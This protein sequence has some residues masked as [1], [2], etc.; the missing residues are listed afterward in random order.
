MYLIELLTPLDQF[1]LQTYS[2]KKIYTDCGEFFLF[3]NNSYTQNSAEFYRTV[4]KCRYN[5]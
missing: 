2:F 5:N 1:G 3:P 4:D